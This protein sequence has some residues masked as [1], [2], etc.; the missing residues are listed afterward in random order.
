MRREN[1]ITDGNKKL[2]S[3]ALGS[4]P[5]LSHHL[6]FSVLCPDRVESSG[7]PVDRS[8]LRQLK[9]STDLAVRILEIL[10]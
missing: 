1:K 10:K 4:I 2:N 7:H 6:S 3:Y 8:G 9:G 5:S